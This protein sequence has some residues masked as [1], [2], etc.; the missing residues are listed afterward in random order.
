MVDLHTS[1]QKDLLK[2]FDQNN[3]K[4]RSQTTGLSRVS[5]QGSR[6]SCPGPALTRLSSNTTDNQSRQSI[7]TQDSR[8]T[9]EDRKPMTFAGEKIIGNGSFGVIYQARVAETGEVVAVKKVYQDRRYKNRELQI[10]QE[11]NHCN[12]VTL[13]YSFLTHDSPEEVYLNLVMDYVPETIYRVFKQYKKQKQ[14]FPPLL[15][16]L[17]S[18]QMFRA[19]AYLHSLNILHRDFKPQNLLVDKMS[20]IL[21][22][23]DF[24]SSKKLNKG[25][26]NVA[27]I[28]SRYYRAPEL[29]FGSTNYD[30]AIDVWSAGCIIGELLLGE[31]LF[32]GDSTMDQMIEIIKK[33]G[34]PTQEEILEMNPKAQQQKFPKIP[35]KP[36]SKVFKTK[37]DPLVLDLLEKVLM[38]NPHKRL[39]AVEALAHPYF[40]ELRDEGCKVDGKDLPNLFDFSQQE[41]GAIQPDLYEKIV[42][43]W[44]RMSKSRFSHPL[45]QQQK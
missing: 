6:L 11:I 40:E 41:I 14:H 43:S 16:K 24:G 45:K 9:V 10:M 31:P 44:A 18:F 1:C 42:P 29:V 34:T 19:L 20:H 7:K 26:N 5:T 15:I 30:G 38:Y 27:Y 4:Y 23:C 2:E 28:C 8:Q 22:V 37:V 32:P 21:K 35:P 12:I 33:L 25:E 13:K 3:A 17:Y 36:W 39:T